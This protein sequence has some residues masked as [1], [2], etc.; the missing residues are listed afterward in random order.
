[1]RTSSTLV[2]NMKK[3]AIEMLGFR[4]QVLTFLCT[5]FS[6]LPIHMYVTFTS[7]HMYMLY[8]QK[9]ARTY[10]PSRPHYA[11]GTTQIALASALFSFIAF[12][13]RG[14]TASST[15]PFPTL[16]SRFLARMTLL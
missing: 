11:C 15:F 6:D 4:K 9:I 1:M 2:T 7:R 5:L 16:A 3:L 14:R 12:S 10:K 13:P 8:Y